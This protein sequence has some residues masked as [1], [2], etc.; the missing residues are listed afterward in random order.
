VKL[1]AAVDLPGGGTIL[2]LAA[3]QEASRDRVGTCVCAVVGT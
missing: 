3:G 1:A 2:A